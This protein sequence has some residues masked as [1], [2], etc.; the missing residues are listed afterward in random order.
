MAVYY[1]TTQQ[2]AMG[3]LLRPKQVR[4]WIR[5]GI[6]SKL[7]FLDPYTKLILIRLRYKLPEMDVR[8][9]DLEDFDP[10]QYGFLLASN[11]LRQK[12]FTPSLVSVST[13]SAPQMLLSGSL[14]TLLLGLGIYF[15]FKWTNKFDTQAGIRDSRNIF[16]TFVTSLGVCTIV[17]SLS[18]LVHDREENTEAEILDVHMKNYIRPR[19]DELEARWGLRILNLENDDSVAFIA[20]GNRT[21][22]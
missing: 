20:N 19:K 16:I 4:A 11:H 2:R 18:S 21:R 14:M 22:V 15:G 1:A 10:D 13:I 8:P 3:R 6:G 7:S 12:S 5:G 9:C 17:Y